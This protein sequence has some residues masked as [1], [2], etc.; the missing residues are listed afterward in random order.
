MSKSLNSSNT[1]SVFYTREEDYVTKL[2]YF[3]P[4]Q[5]QSVLE[6]QVSDHVKKKIPTLKMFDKVLR[7]SE[8]LCN[9]L[10]PKP[11]IVLPLGYKRNKL[12]F[13]EDRPDNEIFEEKRQSKFT[14][15]EK[16]MQRLKNK[17]N[18]CY[19]KANTLAEKMR[20]LKTDSEVLNKFAQ[21][22][23]FEKQCSL[24]GINLNSNNFTGTMKIRAKIQDKI[25]MI[26]NLM[27]EKFSEIHQCKRD[28]DDILKQINEDKSSLKEVKKKYSQV[29]QELLRH[30]N[31]ILKEGKDTRGEGLS[32]IIKRIWELDEEVLLSSMPSFVDNK[33]IE[34]L[35]LI[36]KLSLTKEEA[37]REL[38]LVYKKIAKKNACNG[39][40]KSPLEKKGKIRY[41]FMSPEGKN[42]IVYKMDKELEELSNSP[43]LSLSQI[44]NVVDLYDKEMININKEVKKYM[45]QIQDKK[46]QIKVA[47]VR[48]DQIKKKE[49]ERI[50]R[51]YLV[52]DYE[53]R[54]GVPIMAIISVIIGEDHLES[55]MNGVDK[56]KASFMKTLKSIRNYNL[57]KIKEYQKK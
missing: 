52:N 35:F 11:S 10:T 51:E 57:L 1:L 7:K 34:T 13:F 37:Q 20:E 33:L 45:R 28:H 47:Q 29:K 4:G 16:E 14:Q 54:Y 2:N 30:Y 36:S 31:T 42:G 21:F 50:N 56:E 40:L 23:N 32:W 8:S 5:S 53:R 44:S 48:I 9:F 39:V 46:F 6:S 27:N 41:K 17:I 26:Q 18:L 55:E 43:R 3:R 24:H 25:L 38:N 22:S 12:Y 15:L 19:N 49:I